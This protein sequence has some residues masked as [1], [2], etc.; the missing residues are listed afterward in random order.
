[1]KETKAATAHP[2]RIRSF[3]RREGRLTKGQQRALDE[4]YPRYGLAPDAPRYDMNTLFGRSASRVLE[5]GFGNG[6]A[7]IAMARA[8]P[9]T[10]FV[11]IEVH[12]PGVGNALLQI[13]KHGIENVRLLC[14]DAAEVLAAKLG[15]A[16]FD[17]IYV[18]F[19]DPWPKKRHHKRRLIQPAFVALLRR[20]LRPGGRLHV[21]TDWQDYAEHISEVMAAVP[22][23]EQ[24]QDAAQRPSTKFE[25]RGRRLG[26]EVWD[27][28]YRRSD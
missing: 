15:D 7:L 4:L 2:R 6:D 3:V 18:L 14:A 27:L 10:D 25:Q 20:K 24:L 26:H 8:R 1:M 21:A 22:G 28:V 9:Q 16:T 19:P 23:F 5:I 12:R 13:E 11:G 17:E